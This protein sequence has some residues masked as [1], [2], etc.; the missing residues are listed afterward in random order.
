M[1]PGKAALVLCVHETCCCQ[2]SALGLSTGRLLLPHV[3]VR[4]LPGVP[5]QLLSCH[6][7]HDAASVP[8]LTALMLAHVAICWLPAGWLEAV[9]VWQHFQ[10]VHA[11]L[12]CVTAIAVQPA[13]V[14]LQL[15]EQLGYSWVVLGPVS[16]VAS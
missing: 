9:C 2:R 11:K 12:I 5:M 3:L 13:L 8:S 16:W 10:A 14:R 1:V 6:F 4:A 7:E 15:Q